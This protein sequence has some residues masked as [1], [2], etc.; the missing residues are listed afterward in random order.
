MQQGLFYI[1]TNEN[2]L[3]PRG[4]TKLSTQPT[5]GWAN[6][7]DSWDEWGWACLPCLPTGN[8]ELSKKSPWSLYR[9]RQ[10]L[11]QEIKR[12]RVNL[13]VFK[14]EVTLNQWWIHNP[15]NASLSESYSS[16]KSWSRKRQ[17]EV[18][19]SFPPSIS[20]QGY[21][22]WPFLYAEEGKMDFPSTSFTSKL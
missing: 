3:G 20:L 18:K 11:C 1:T 9:S 17:R 14:E 10:L 19:G 7:T 21:K 6:C 16:I 15:M 2:N 8:S 5:K 22:C 13:V 4:R 12:G